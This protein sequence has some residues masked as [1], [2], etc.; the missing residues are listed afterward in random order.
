MVQR[1]V[2]HK[3][4]M[5]RVGED[6]SGTAE[7]DLVVIYED[8]ASLELR[9]LAALSHLADAREWS[10]PVSVDD[11]ILRAIETLRGSR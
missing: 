11:A 10:D 1:Y 5:H 2:V 3:S 8:Y 7:W 9:V 4:E 6:E